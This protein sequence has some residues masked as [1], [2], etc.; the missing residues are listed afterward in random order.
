MRRTSLKTALIAI[1]FVAFYVFAIS[2][3]DEYYLSTRTVYFG[4]HF[5]SWN[6]WDYVAT[7]SL[8]LVFAL[9]AVTVMFL[10]K[11]D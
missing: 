11:G 1:G 9:A 7:G 10:D 4:L 6:H 3:A 2:A 5:R 8:I